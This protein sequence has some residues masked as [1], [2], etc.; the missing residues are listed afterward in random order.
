VLSLNLTALI[1]GF[2]NGTTMVPDT[3]TVELRNNTV[4]YTLVE[5]KNIVLGATGTASPL[6]TTAVNG[7]SY[8]IVLKHRNSLETWS[9]APQTFSSSALSYDFTTAATQAYGSNMILV[10]TKWCLYNGDAN[11]DGAVDALDMIAIDNDVANFIIGYISTDINGDGAVDA[12]DMIICDNNTANFVAAIKPPGAPSVLK[13]PR[14][15]EQ[16]KALEKYMKS[17]IEQKQ[18]NDKLKKEKTEN[19]NKIKSTKNK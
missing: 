2:Y 19:E 6:F 4:P 12:L 14:T 1:Q 7:T 18:V 9:A 10:G 13:I 17:W 11:L 5:S 15:Y 8:Y 16:I 3:I